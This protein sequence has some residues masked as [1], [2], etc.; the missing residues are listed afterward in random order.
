M[1]VCFIPFIGFAAIA[2]IFASCAKEEKTAGQHTAA[3]SNKQ[4]L[5]APASEEKIYFQVGKNYYSINTDGSDPKN[6]FEGNDPSASADGKT[7][8]YTEDG[9]G[10]SRNIALYDVASGKKKI[11]NAIPGNNSYGAQISPDGM[12]I[13]FS[14]YSNHN[15]TIA[16]IDTSGKN[17]RIL[18][19]ISGKDQYSG[20]YSAT[21]ISDGTGFLCHNLDTIYEFSL[22]GKNLRKIA[23][24]SI[25]GYDISHIS[26]S[27][28]F[29]LDVK[30]NRL[31][32]ESGDDL[33]D[34]GNEIGDYAIYTYDLNAKKMQRL[35]SDKM[36]A[37][38]PV[39]S[40]GANRFYFL[41]F[42]ASDIDIH[43]PFFHKWYLYSIGEDGSDLKKIFAT[44]P[45]TFR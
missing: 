10:G 5:P 28:H 15:W 26:S 16:I 41:G 43:K 9:K 14:H 29:Y 11:I 24:S 22:E 45:A 39:W 23:V 44:E 4:N 8:A 25:S 40:P 7:I 42:E 31:Y 12:M 19:P 35:S 13:L 2:L 36:Y 33:E 1:H 21:W 37:I 17:F 30:K 34:Q 3:D 27:S 6:I 32:F 18:T 20:Y 38:A